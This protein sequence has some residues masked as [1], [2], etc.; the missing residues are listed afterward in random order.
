[1]NIAEK[2][3]KEAKHLPEPLAREVL[4]FIG[5]LEYRHGLRDPATEDLR[6]A[7]HS[8]L[9]KIWNNPEDEVWNDM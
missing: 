7:Q 5:Y 2:T 1:M 6:N 8:A 9:E 3:H 4:S